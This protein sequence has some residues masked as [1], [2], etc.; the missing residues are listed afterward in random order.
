MEDDNIKVLAYNRCSTLSQELEKDRETLK[1]SG[2]DELFEEKK[3]GTKIEGR[4][5]LEKML[6]RLKE[7][8]SQNIKVIIKVVKLDRIARSIIDFNNIIQEIIDNRGIIKFLDNGMQYGNISEDEFSRAQ[9]ELMLNQ[10]ASF[11]QFEAAM[12]KARTMRG[13]QY[14]KEHDKNFKDGRKRKL[15]K[16][17]VLDA[18][19]LLNKYSY[20]EVAK[21][22]GISRRTLFN[23]VERVKNDEY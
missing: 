19:E 20:S 4:I 2:Y 3:S 6:L 8:H 9:N 13:K 16:E 10:L 23:Y 7:L 12:I 15:C 22:K 5:E 17:E 1:I 18:M 14:K 11:S 21:R